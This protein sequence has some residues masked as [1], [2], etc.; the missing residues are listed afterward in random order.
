MPTKNRRVATY[1]PKEI[2][3]CFQV[4]KAG[5]NI[6]GD[7]QALIIILSEFLGVGQNVT[8]SVDYSNYV[9]VEQF[10]NLL[11][12]IEAQEKPISVSESNSELLNRLQALESRIEVLEAL[13]GEKLTLTTGELAKRL[14]IDSSTLS[15]WKSTGKKGKSPDEL[16][17]ATREKDPD[18]IGWILILETGRFKPEK[19]LQ[20]KHDVVSQGEL[21]SESKV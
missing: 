17:K 20:N 19:D 14:G 8:H 5:R 10:D 9:T 13:Q 4:F 3:D 18:G 15:H 12:K 6:E 21:L 11:A 2:D 16:L 1:L 7:S